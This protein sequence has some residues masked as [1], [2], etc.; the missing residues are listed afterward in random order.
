MYIQIKNQ[1][2]NFLFQY[3]ESSEIVKSKISESRLKK[4]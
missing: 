4:K 1:L 3:N 2:N